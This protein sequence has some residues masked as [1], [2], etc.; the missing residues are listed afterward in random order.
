VDFFVEFYNRPNCRGAL[1]RWPGGEAAT[2]D[3]L[4]GE[5][6]RPGTEKLILVASQNAGIHKD[7]RQGSEIHSIT[8]I[9]P[10]IFRASDYAKLVGE[11]IGAVDICHGTLDTVASRRP[12]DVTLTMPGQRLWF[13]LMTRPGAPHDRVRLCICTRPDLRVA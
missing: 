7:E 11:H 12:S 3:Y 1:F 5:P 13:S 6:L 10:R 4:S 9:F 2:L 8:R